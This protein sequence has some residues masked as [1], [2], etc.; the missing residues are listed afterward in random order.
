MSDRYAERVGKPADMDFKG[1][2][3][4]TFPLWGTILDRIKNN[5]MACYKP[6]AV[7]FYIG[8]LLTYVTSIRPG[9]QKKA[10]RR[11]LAI[12]MVSYTVEDM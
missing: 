12:I 10:V 5:S 9:R 4:T 11:I 2:L 6:T 8:P 1:Y 7:G 3:N